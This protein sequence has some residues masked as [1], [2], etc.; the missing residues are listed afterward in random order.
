M[1]STENFT[2]ANI[3]T[4]WTG[5]ALKWGC[6]RDFLHPPNYAEESYLSQTMGVAGAAVGW[7][8]VRPIS[9]LIYGIAVGLLIAPLGAAYHLGGAIGCAL[10]SK[11]ERAWEHLKSAKFDIIAIILG[12]GGLGL[13]AAYSV[14]GDNVVTIYQ[15]SRPA[16]N[17][18]RPVMCGSLYVT[19]SFFP[20]TPI[21]IEGSDSPIP[22]ATYVTQNLYST[23]L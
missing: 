19:S 11:K 3:P 13:G 23:R 18:T 10:Q 1:A 15:L 22:Y 4:S 8:I 14:G 12:V 5:L 6:E 21:K 20:N 9:R 2:L 7:A 17:I 16:Y